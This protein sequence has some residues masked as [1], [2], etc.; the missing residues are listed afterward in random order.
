MRTLTSLFVVA[1]SVSALSAPLTPGTLYKLPKTLVCGNTKIETHFRVSTTTIEDLAT[2]A[3]HINPEET[4]SDHHWLASISA[5]SFS[6]RFWG[7]DDSGSIELN[8][9]EI[10]EPVSSLVSTK[11]LQ[12]QSYYELR[13]VESTSPVQCTVIY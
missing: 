1:L 7:C 12:G 6:A 11:V 5:T 3:N 2:K 4:G 8:I 10:L 13:D 9:E